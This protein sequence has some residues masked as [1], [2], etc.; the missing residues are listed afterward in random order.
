MATT[1]F[2]E[3][4]IR[5]QI[6]QRSGQV[7]ISQVPGGWQFID[8]LSGRALSGPS[9]TS[10]IMANPQRPNDPKIKAR[11]L[12]RARG[13][14]QGQSVP[15][16]FIEAIATVAAYVSATRGIPV[17]DLFQDGTMGNE[18]LR[19][20]NSFKPKGSQVGTLAPGRVP[21]WTNNPTLRGSIT[22]AISE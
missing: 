22:A 20:Y 19:A 11:A 5:Q 4:T 8:D 18:L 12:D 14:Y 17:D 9:A 2:V 10:S 1:N 6:A 16:E 13:Y 15:A 3:E 7:S 21:G